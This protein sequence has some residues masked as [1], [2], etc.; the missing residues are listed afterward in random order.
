MSKDD[1]I[2]Y[3]KNLPIEEEFNKEI[4]DEFLLKKLI[5]IISK[6]KINK[7]GI[8][9]FDYNCL[10]SKLNSI[11]VSKE[12][13]YL[14]EN[15]LVKDGRIILEDNKIMMN[16][17]QI[18]YEINID[19]LSKKIKIDE[20]KFRENMYNQTQNLKFKDSNYK[21]YKPNSE[22]II[23]YLIGDILDIQKYYKRIGLI[24]Y[25]ESKA[26]DE[27]KEIFDNSIINLIKIAQKGDLGVILYLK[28][29]WLDFQFDKIMQ[30]II[31][32]VLLWLGIKKIEWFIP[33]NKSDYKYLSGEKIIVK[34]ISELIENNKNI[35]QSDKIYSFEYIRE[36][37]KELYNNL[38]LN[39]SLY[40]TLDLGN[41]H[42]LKNKI[43]KIL[44]EK[45][46]NLKQYSVLNYLELEKKNFL[47]IL[48]QKLEKLSYY[49]KFKS[50]VDFVFIT[51]LVD[52][53][54]GDEWEYTYDDCKYKRSEGIVLAMYN[55]F[56]SGYF[57][58]TDKLYQVNTKN[59]QE[60]KYK[61]LKEK[62]QNESLKGIKNRLILLNNLGKILKEKK[63]NRPSDFF[64][65]FNLKDNI[66][67]KYLWN[68]VINDLK[69]LWNNG[70]STEYFRGDI[71]EHIIIKDPFIE[72]SKYIP[73]HNSS[74]WVIYSI[75]SVIKLYDVYNLKDEEILT[76]IHNYSNLLFLIK[77]DVLRIKKKN[78]KK[79][80]ID[81][82]FTIELR[83]LTNNIINDILKDINLETKKEYLMSELIENGIIDLN[84]NY[85][86]N[87]NLILDSF[88][89]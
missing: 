15:N 29:E 23:I 55:L 21:I 38:K 64:D 85:K 7:K 66:S 82:I 16:K 19:K 17:I 24:T 4:K 57:S 26:I 51:C 6:N 34:N 40:F 45:E 70:N 89:L 77:T 75:L 76:S 71:W 60:I 81:S 50:L 2:F 20:K 8:S 41:Y 88:Y 54:T 73:F 1:K 30:I 31:N 44:L 10:E 78:K 69:D 72:N 46:K 56:T 32:E 39:K 74:Q 33:L 83:S 53:Y 52:T 18:K 80:T 61:N 25:Y 87:K 11:F 12:K 14:P 28:N 47:K 5:K 42:K 49:E 27:K 48:L 3:L 35:I 59:L 36:I 62:F 68:F 43:K 22:G 84:K 13:L 9:S 37:N 86:E 67:T 65:N 58:N 79:I 63:L